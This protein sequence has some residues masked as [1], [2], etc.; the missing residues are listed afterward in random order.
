[1][2]I[3][4]LAKYAIGITTGAAMLAA[5]SSN[6]G[7]SLAPSGA[8]GSMPMI[9]H[10]GKLTMVNG[11]LMTAAH[12]NL[13]GLRGGLITPDKHHKKKAGDQFI[14]DFGN[15]VVDEFD[16]PK[17]DSSIGSISGISE[18]QGE[19]TN[20]LFGSG[21]KTFWVTASGSLTTDEFKVGGS[22]P[23]KT[24]NAPSGDTPVGCAIDPKTGNLASTIINNGAVV[25]YTKAS[26]AGTV[27]QSP[28]IEAFFAGYDT[29]SNLY[30]DGFNNQGEFGL[31]ELKKGSSTWQTLSLSNSIEFPGNVQ[32]D[33]KYITVNDQEAHDIF[34]YT[35]SGTSCTLEQTV[36]LSGS[37][38]CD[39]T[40]IAKGYA[41]CP[42][43]GNVDGEIYKYPA[44]GSPVAVLT[45]SFSEPLAASAATK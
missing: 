34:G 40:W 16:Y 43:A 45:A 31:V 18:A 20:V 35:C 14:S 21:K 12:P 37:S 29:G 9:S 13:A 10:V 28:L 26:G 36:S 27:S 39:Q 23:I 44:G 3:S 6:G 24:L 42:D 5:C 4:N 41:I 25:I 1:M 32:F 38:D 33:G 7:S 30:V 11:V 15:G 22:S 8:T 17:S 19:C 2:K